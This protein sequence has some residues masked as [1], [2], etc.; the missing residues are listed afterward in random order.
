MK[1]NE[2]SVGQ[3]VLIEATVRNVDI[4]ARHF[5]AV[6]VRLKS[7]QVIS[8]DHEDISE[9]V[10]VRPAKEPFLPDAQKEEKIEEPKKEEKPKKEISGLIRK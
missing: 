1:L 4:H 10:K 3:K 5:N 8:V 7:G 2:I 9:S 6:E